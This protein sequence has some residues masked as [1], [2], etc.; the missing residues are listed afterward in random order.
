MDHR[1]AQ[2]PAKIQDMFKGQL[3]VK[4]LLLVAHDNDS[5]FTNKPVPW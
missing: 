2:R 3:G 1:L 4:D 5:W